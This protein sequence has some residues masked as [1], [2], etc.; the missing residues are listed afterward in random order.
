MKIEELKAEWVSN[1]SLGPDCSDAE[2]A[3][4]FVEKLLAVAEAAQDSRLNSE[5]WAMDYNV[6]ERITDALD[7]LLESK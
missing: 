3:H 7:D 5:I 1:R 2:F 6:A 4:R